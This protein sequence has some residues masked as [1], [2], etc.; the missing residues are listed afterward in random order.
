MNT[1]RLFNIG[2]SVYII[3]G[4]IHLFSHFFGTPAD[5]SF[6]ELI[7]IM[8]ESTIHIGGAHSVLKFYNGF[9]VM[10]GVMLVCFGLVSF[11]MAK[12]IVHRLQVFTLYCA[13]ALGLFIVS[14]LYF[15]ILTYGLLGVTLVAHVISY[16]NFNYN[17]TIA[18]PEP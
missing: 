17:P 7:A 12:T 6:D 4:I 1:V 10:M 2:T 16:F 11:L 3:L 15:H 13:I 8:E 18:I 9:S 14:I 5:P